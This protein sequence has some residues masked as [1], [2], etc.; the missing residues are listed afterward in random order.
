MDVGRICR[1]SRSA[2]KA[3]PL[4]LLSGEIPQNAAVATNFNFY[5]PIDD[6]FNGALA[7]IWT[8]SAHYGRTSRKGLGTGNGCHRHHPEE[9]TL[10]HVDHPEAV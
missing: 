6:Y 8:T 1:Q 4:R 7:A 10:I 9:N 2:F 3:A 5:G